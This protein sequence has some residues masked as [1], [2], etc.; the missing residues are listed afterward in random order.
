M[1]TVIQPSGT[2]IRPEMPCINIEL[3][4]I[5][6]DIGITKVLLNM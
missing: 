6:S 2:E 1:R 4:K 3:L 5:A